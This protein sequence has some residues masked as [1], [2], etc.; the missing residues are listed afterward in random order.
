MG[1]GRLRALAAA[2]AVVLAL[3][4]CAEAEDAAGEACAASCRSLARRVR[5]RYRD[6]AC[7]PYRQ[8]M[9]RPRVMRA[10][11]RHLEEVSLEVCESAC[12]ARSGRVAGAGADAGASAGADAG[13][14]A[15]AEAAPP[16]V[17]GRAARRRRVAERTARPRPG[18]AALDER[19]AAARRDAESCAELAEL[20]GPMVDAC[21]DGRRFGRRASLAVLATAHAEFVLGDGSGDGD[22]ADAA[23]QDWTARATAWVA[24]MDGAARDVLEGL[25]AEAR[26][27]A[28]QRGA[29]AG[30]PRG[31]GRAAGP[32]PP[33]EPAAGPAAGPH[34]A[35]SV[36]NDTVLVPTPAGRSA[37]EHAASFCASA[38]ADGGN[39]SSCVRLLTGYLAAAREGPPPEGRRSADAGEI[40]AI[41]QGRGVRALI[42]E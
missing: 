20:P 32:D 13:G 38:G 30:E 9:P 41:W 17:R 18:A 5:D 22:R 7:G 35:V 10:C 16:L 27:R 24:E 12:A 37:A 11:A 31:A 3:G 14:G 2:V 33:V 4:G 29:A 36:G 25:K 26:R 1:R 6:A 42:V 34:V 15:G 19:S 28:E 8:A 39:R 21:A 23:G 40:L